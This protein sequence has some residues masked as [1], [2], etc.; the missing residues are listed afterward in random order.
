MSFF[1]KIIIAHIVTYIVVGAIS[2]ELL[3]YEANLLEIF[4]LRNP[5]EIGLLTIVFAQI[6]RGILL[7][8]VIWWIK[9]IIMGKKLAWLKLSAILVILGIFNTYAPASGSI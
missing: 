2:S 7:G 6:V 1:T 5:D 8:I 9:D 4:G 3:N